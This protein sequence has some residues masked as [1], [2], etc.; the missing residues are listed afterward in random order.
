MADMKEPTGTSP[1][2]GPIG[3]GPK[4]GA[5]GAEL[6]TDPGKPPVDQKAQRK[7][8]A[9]KAKAQAKKAAKVAKAVKGGKKGAEPKDAE[10]KKS[11]LKKLILLVPVVAIAGAGMLFFG[12]GGSEEEG[13][14]AVDTDHIELA[15]AIV[16]I[17]DFVVNLSSDNPD[18]LRYAK[19]AVSIGVDSEETQEH[20]GEVSAYFSDAIVERIA[21]STAEELG[22]AEGREA[23]K[24]DLLVEFQNMAPHGTEIQKVLFTQLAFQ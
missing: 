6:K 5:P 9:K 21:S 1:S 3:G 22:S 8:D 24:A 19:V 14:P 10:S 12:G 23:V 17:G 11:P 2:P 16:D 7:A 4:G 18:E 15:P 20:L 13:A